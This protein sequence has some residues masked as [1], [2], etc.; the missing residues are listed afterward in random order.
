MA[1]LAQRV[2]TALQAVGADIKALQAHHAQAVIYTTGTV[3]PT[4]RTDIMVI[5]IGANPGAAMVENLDVWIE[6]I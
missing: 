3:R 5:F 4:S 2:T 1:T 6:N